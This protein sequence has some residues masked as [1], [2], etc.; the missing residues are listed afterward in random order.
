MS[1]ASLLHMLYIYIY[2]VFYMLDVIIGT[3]DAT[4]NKGDNV[5][6]LMVLT[7]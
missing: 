3:Q 4:E 6:A 2:S 1:A 5:P 7:F